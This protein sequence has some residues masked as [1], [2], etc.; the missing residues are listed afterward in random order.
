MHKL[1]ETLKIILVGN[2]IKV[3]SKYE[4]TIINKPLCKKKK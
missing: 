1:P 4:N 3:L 2:K